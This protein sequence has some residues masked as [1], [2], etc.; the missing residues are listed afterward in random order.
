MHLYNTNPNLQNMP[1][2]EFIERTVGTDA[3]QIDKAEAIKML[4]ELVLNTAMNA[5]RDL[6]LKQD[7]LNKGNGLYE[8]KLAAG[9]FN[10]DLNVPRDREGNF[11]PALLPPKYKRT[12]ASY[13]NL[14]S[15]LVVNGYSESQLFL[16]LK[17]LGLPYSQDDMSF[18]RKQISDRLSDFKQKELPESA[19]ALLIDAYHCQIKENNKIQKACIYSVMG[20]DLKGQ[21]DVYGFYTFFGNE[22][23]IDWRKVFGDLVQRGLKKAVVIIS[24][25]FP[26]MTDAVKA[27][28]PNTDHQLC[29]VHFMRNVRRNMK[30]PDASLFNKEIQNIKLSKNLDDGIAQFEKLCKSF[31]KEYPTFISYIE[32]KKECFFSFLRFPEEIRKHLYTTNAVENLNSRIETIRLKLGGYFQSVNIFEINLLLQIERWQHA[33]WK[34]PVPTL[35]G[36]TYELHQIFNCKFYTQTQSS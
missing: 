34:N 6:Y 5:E 26:A 16:S 3:S 13:L 32:M 22:S 29:L 28:Y 9:S 4:L 17:Q 10:L 15:S 12:D 25:D 20:I 1:V 19:F 30:A 21:K 24:D 35:Q 14:L 33:Q 31:K 27:F 23:V 36:K 18:I 2:N 8:R 7:V 11:R